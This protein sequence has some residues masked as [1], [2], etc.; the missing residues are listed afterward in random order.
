MILFGYGC[1]QMN[2]IN[3]LVGAT[4][5]IGN[6]KWGQNA[7]NLL[8]DNNGS[9]IEELQLRAYKITYFFTEEKHIEFEI[10]T[11]LTNQISSHL[12]FH[13]KF[14]FKN[15]LFLNLKHFLIENWLDSLIEQ[16]SKCWFYT[17]K[18]YEPDRTKV[19][20]F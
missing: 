5:E 20:N 8:V 14:L 13:W 4:N 15:P 19:I 17:V 18:I 1:K 11:R 16:Q 7:Q 10:C 6:A 2:S 3:E 12:L 9:Q